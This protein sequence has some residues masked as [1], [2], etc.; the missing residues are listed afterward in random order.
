MLLSASWASQGLD[1]LFVLFFFDYLGSV[2]E[3][4]AV[5]ASGRRKSLPEE[6][7]CHDSFAVMNMIGC[8]R[9]VLSHHHLVCVA[10]D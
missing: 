7:I 5:H 6:D 1:S 4:G 10:T 3:E 9:R 2:D 8:D